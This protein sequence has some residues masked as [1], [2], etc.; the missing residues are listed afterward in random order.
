[1]TELLNKPDWEA[2][3][4][5][6]K[7]WWAREDIGRPAISI[8][9]PKDGVPR[10]EPPPPPEKVE[11]RWLDTDYR[12]RLNDYNIR[13][14]YYGGEAFPVWETGDGWMQQA[15]YLGCPV[16]MDEHSGWLGSILHGESLSDHDYRELVP[17]ENELQRA[18]EN[19]HI[20]AA[21]FAK[22]KSIPAIQALGAGT[23]VLAALRGTER[24]LTDCLECP[25]YLREFDQYLAK[26]W[27]DI[28]D[29]LYQI[30]CEAAEGSTCWP[31]VGLWAPGRFYMLQCDFSYMISPEM[32]IE[33]FLPG[34]EIN[35]NYLDYSVYHLDGVGAFAHV[36]ALCQLPKLNGI[37]VLPGDGKPSALYYKDILKKVQDAG[38]NLQIYIAP[39]EISTALELLSPQG[40][41]LTTWADSEEEAKDLLRMVENR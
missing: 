12:K 38:K 8:R 14:T 11:N 33:L 31:G 16:N 21:K 3:K 25:D 17:Q 28:H 1:M 39:H 32:F 7:A 35:A 10:E 18:S 37:Q 27:N 40:L 26:Q 2:V 30:T 23:D 22:G 5:R 34:I 9:A 29:R 20:C 15:A 41:L 19:M 6:M 13:R 24:L 36:D 4:E